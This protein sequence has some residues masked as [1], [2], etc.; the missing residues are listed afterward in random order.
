MCK[1]LLFP[2]NHG[3]KENKETAKSD[4][5]YPMISFNFWINKIDKANWINTREHLAI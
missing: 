2:K 5:L 3:S 1:S 4:F